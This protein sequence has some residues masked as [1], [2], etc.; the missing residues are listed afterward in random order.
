[1]IVNYEITYLPDKLTSDR[2]DRCIEVLPAEYYDAENNVYILIYILITRIY[3]LNI[4][5]KITH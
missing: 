4:N 2:H 3:L 1:M 5:V